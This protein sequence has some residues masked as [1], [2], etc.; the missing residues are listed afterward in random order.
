MRSEPVELVIRPIA[1]SGTRVVGPVDALCEEPGALELVGAPDEVAPDD[2]GLDRLPPWLVAKGVLLT[3]PGAEVEPDEPGP[4]APAQAES[5]TTAATRGSI[6]RRTGMRI[7]SPSG[8]W[9]RALDHG[10]SPR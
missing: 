9:E 3:P 6:V 10:S 1:P 5:R 8:S 4:F 2:P 7:R